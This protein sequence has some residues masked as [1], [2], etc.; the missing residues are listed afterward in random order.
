MS[1]LTLN[2]AKHYKRV[3]QETIKYKK[4]FKEA[5]KWP[6]IRKDVKWQHRKAHL[7]Q[8]KQVW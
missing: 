3:R 6:H 4:L 8:L 5:A 7:R 1:K 2:K